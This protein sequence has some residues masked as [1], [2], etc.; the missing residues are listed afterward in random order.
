MMHHFTRAFAVAANSLTILHRGI[1]SRQEAQRIVLRGAE[2]VE[3]R[4]KRTRCTLCV[5]LMVL[6]FVSSTPSAPQTI[7]VL[8]REWQVSLASWVRQN[9]FP[10]KL[11]RSL[12][13]RYGR[14][15]S[16]T[17]FITTGNAENSRSIVKIGHPASSA[18]TKP[19][20]AAA[21]VLNAPTNMAVELCNSCVPPSPSSTAINLSWTAP[22]GTVAY[23]RVERSQSPQGPFTVIANPVSTSH[24][25]NTV[26]S[27][28]AYLYRV[29][30]VDSF[31]AQSSPS[32]MVLGTAITFADATLYA[33]T[34]EIRKQHIYDLR[35]SVNA[36]RAIA[37]LGAFAWTNSDLTGLEVQALHVQQLRDKLDEALAALSVPVTSYN[38]SSLATGANG[39]EI[40]KIHIEQLRLRSTS[41][42]STSTGS[43]SSSGDSAIARLDPSNETGGGGENPL[44]R[45]YNLN[46]P[47]LGLPGRAGLDLGLS[48]SSN[49]LVWT[50]SGSYISFNDDGLPSPG[51]RLGFP[52][53]QPL[54][55]NSQVGKNAFLLI[56]PGGERVELRQVGTSNLYES[57][58]S[59]YLVLD[60]STMI[61]R[62]KD[63]TQ[64]S[65]AWMGSDYQCTQIKDRNGNFITI[66]YTGFG[67]IDTVIDTLSR[68]IK[69]NYDVNNYL[70]SITQTWTV[71]GQVQT[72]TWATFTYSNPNLPIQTNFPGLTVIGPQNGTSIKVLTRVTL[73]D[74]ARYDFDYTSWGQIW[75]VSNFAPDGHLLNYRSYNLPLNNS[76]AQADCP[77]FTERRDWVENWNRSGPLGPA[78]LPVGSEQEVITQFIV[79]VS[80]S[81]TMPD[82]TQQTG[83]RAQVTL[84]DNSSHKIYFAG[85]AGTSSGWQ[86]GLVS[87][88]ETYDSAGTWQRKSVNTWTQD[89]TALSYPLN[90][91]VTETNT[92]DPAGNR[93]RTR[94]T[95]QSVTFTD[96]TSCNLP[97]DVYEYQAN[98][99]S[100]LRRTHTDYNL[101]TTYTNRRIIGL[102]SEK[103]LYEVDPNTQAE[104]LM[105]KVGFQY[106][107]AGSIQG[108]D[109]PVQHD[110]TNYGSSFV[111]GRANLSSVKRYD[112]VTSQF[113]TSSSKYNT[114]GSVVQTT[115]P[116]NHQVSVT[117]TDAFS[118]DGTNLDAPRPFVTLAY[119]TTVT[120][121][122]GYSSSARYHYDF[123]AATWK[124]TPQPNTT[125]NTPGPVQKLT[126]DNLGRLQQVTNLVNSAYTRFIYGPNYVESWATG[127]IVESCV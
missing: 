38:D 34:T 85:T 88:V 15:S 64:L 105:S 106:D 35:Q 20:I 95:Y 123:G 100:V 96:G 111:S 75:K 92:Y 5:A 121:A 116:A 82:S 101:G 81:W 70:S 16:W 103:S 76:T 113:V 40:K 48:L 60:S 63:G 74:S 22:T 108:V 102:V 66:N 90:P 71:N 30:A 68:T 67:R 109:A 126:Y 58:D 78:L 107:E 1:R 114:A 2:A 23:Y 24:P 32:T 119:P 12:L 122:D 37:G 51:F 86:R 42:S 115:D 13:D 43:V 79:P 120:D 56:T 104:T 33:G 19:M 53:I 94:V 52:V 91:R 77:R 46:I 84:Q 55:Y 57:A 3:R 25:D 99:T 28:A 83:T 89:N 112:V 4:L 61:L 41:G 80:E 62:T 59:S 29:R 124:Q 87:L 110:N 93:A 8:S 54:Y 11:Y 7:V 26:S 125:V 118:A 18:A 49:S 73:D 45:N 97:Q 36:V 17:S 6:L 27:G 14:Y 69:F 98:A 10:T 65:Y 44:S 21:V 117:Y 39:T 127:V 72:H 47:L 50:K 31:G 9:Q